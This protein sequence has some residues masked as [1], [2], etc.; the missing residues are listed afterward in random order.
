MFGVLGF[1]VFGFWVLGVGGTPCPLKVCRR[2][3]SSK[4]HIFTV[5][6]A[7]PKASRG[8]APELHATHFRLPTNGSRLRV[9]GLGFMICGSGAIG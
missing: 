6:S 4:F 9:S 1:W 2:S 7:D 5:L 8:L 3:S